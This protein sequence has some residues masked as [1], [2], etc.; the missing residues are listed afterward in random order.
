ML[1]YLGGITASMCVLKYDVGVEWLLIS[2][3]LTVSGARYLVAT[4]IHHGVHHAIFRSERSNR[5]LCEFLS[6]ITVVQPFDSYRQFHVYEHHGRDFSTMSDQD[7]AAIYTLGLRPGVPVERMRWILLW[8]C[9]NPLFHVRYF[10]VRIKS[11]FV[12]VPLYR[13]AMISVWMVLLASVAYIVGPFVFLVSIGIPLTVIYQVCSLLHLV[14]EHAWVLR[15]DDERVRE[16]HVKNSHGRFC[17]RML[18]PVGVS[19]IQWFRAWVSWWA[20][21]LLIHLPARLLIV[22]GSLVVHDWHHRS[23]ADRSWPNAIQKRETDLQREFDQG[24]YTYTDIWG[25]HNVIEEVMRRI[26]DA[27]IAAPIQGLKYR[28]N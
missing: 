1:L 2:I 21:H 4:I 23:G 24:T 13:V 8:Q 5:L 11:N 7:L 25:I 15:R 6:A 28:L 22:Q 17:G 14:T 12:N 19:G 27:P 9:V 26:S 3:V 20:E 10:G 18:P 16:S